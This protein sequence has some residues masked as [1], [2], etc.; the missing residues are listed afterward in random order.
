MNIERLRSLGIRFV[1]STHGITKMG[2]AVRSSFQWRLYKRYIGGL[3][4]ED[5]LNEYKGLLKRL[6]ED[7]VIISYPN[8]YSVILYLCPTRL[9]W[10]IY[11]IYW[12]D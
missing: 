8:V 3:S 2:A 10:W 5:Q 12:E 1:A 9:F 4:D 6:K 7:E 11:R